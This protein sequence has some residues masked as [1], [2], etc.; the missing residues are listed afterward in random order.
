MSRWRIAV[1]VLLIAVPFVL[2]AAAGSYYLLWRLGWGFYLWWP[3]AACLSLGYLLAWYWQHKRQL[4]RPVDFQP[5]LHWT[6]RDRQAWQ[7]VEARAKAAAQIDTARLGEIDFYVNA[8]KEM[9]AELAHFYNPRSQDP[10]GPLTIPEILAVLEFSAHDLAD[11]VDQYLP[12]GHLLTINDWRL[13]RQATGWYR[14]ASNAYWL[15]SALF[16]PL[17]TGVRYVASRTG[18][19]HSLQKLQDNLLVW[20]YMAFVQRTG[21]YLIDLYSGRLRVG[22]PRYRELMEKL[23]ANTRSRSQAGERDQTL[24]DA[25][26]VDQ[27]RA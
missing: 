8:A 19:T 27:I 9:A 13:A 1:V 25:D 5:P 6:N 4:L 12:G 2:L 16:S 10:V 21:N 24:A 11:L 3:M 26:S 22:A 15:V 23:A 14:Q 17:E 18:L 20:F 7:L